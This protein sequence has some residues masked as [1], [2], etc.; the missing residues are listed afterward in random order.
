MSRDL[1]Y[2]GS[3]LAAVGLWA[4]AVVALWAVVEGGYWLYCKATGRDY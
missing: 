2:L 1:L 3:A 4:C